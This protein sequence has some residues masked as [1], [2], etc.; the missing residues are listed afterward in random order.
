MP[1]YE[2]F[3]NPKYWNISGKKKYEEVGY[4]C[5]N[6]AGFAYSKNFL[7]LFSEIYQF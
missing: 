5:R 7:I 1:I 6:Y 2:L 4:A 3:W